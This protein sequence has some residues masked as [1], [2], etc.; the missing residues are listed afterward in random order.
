MQ[1]HTADVLEAVKI[2]VVCFQN[3]PS[4]DTLRR[5]VRVCMCVDRCVC[6]HKHECRMGDAGALEH[7][8]NMISLLCVGPVTAVRQSAG[9]L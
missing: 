5:W 2:Q 9:L 3:T 4:P 8:G 7:R 6:T 1:D